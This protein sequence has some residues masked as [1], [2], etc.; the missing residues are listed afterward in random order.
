[1]GIKGVFQA[2]NVAEN[3]RIKT[4]L[5]RIFWESNPHRGIGLNHLYSILNTFIDSLY[6]LWLIKHN[7]AMML[8]HSLDFGS[9][10]PASGIRWIS[11]TPTTAQGQNSKK[12]FRVIFECFWDFLSTMSNFDKMLHN[13]NRGRPN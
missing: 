4:T 7:Y 12:S 11:R 10:I 2:L 6:A 13:I 9:F 8:K 1:M 5:S 3:I